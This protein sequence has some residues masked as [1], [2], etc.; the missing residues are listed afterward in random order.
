MEEFLVIPLKSGVPSTSKTKLL[1]EAL[2]WVEVGPDEQLND[3]I[4]KVFGR[5]TKDTRYLAVLIDDRAVV[6]TVTPT[7]Q[8]VGENFE[9]YRDL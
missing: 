8:V 1:G 6:V 2:R 4:I 9:S 7:V 3:A 5:P